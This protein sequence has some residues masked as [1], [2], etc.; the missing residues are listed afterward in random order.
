M[1]NPFFVKIYLRKNLTRLLL[2][3]GSVR[4]E[5]FL[6]SLIIFFSTSLITL[7]QMKKIVLAT[8]LMALPT[9]TFAGGM[10]NANLSD[11]TQTTTT[12]RSMD[13]ITNFNPDVA[14]EAVQPVVGAI[15]SEI[16]TDTIQSGA[17]QTTTVNIQ[18]T[19]TSTGATTTRRFTL[20]STGIAPD[21]LIDRAEK[22]SLDLTKERQDAARAKLLRYRMMSR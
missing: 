12:T 2:K 7:P 17:V 4:N 14:A 22:S 21:G 11:Y 19:T 18:E 6:L 15:G 5:R 3:I 20:P 16:D 9:L 1:V 8:A 13:F 10:G